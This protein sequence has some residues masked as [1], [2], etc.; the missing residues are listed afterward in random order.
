MRTS[1][2]ILSIV[3]SATV[4]SIASAGDFQ[5]L[6]SKASSMG[7]AGIAT[8][9]S[10]LA[11]YNNPALLGTNTEKL[12]IHI[13]AGV[14]AKDTGA[15]E[16]IGDLNDLDFSG[17][18]DAA[19][20]NADNLTANQIAAL[21]SAKNI[22]VGMDGK[23]I[24]MSPNADFGV[25]YGAFGTGLFVTSDIGAHANI[26]Q[27]HTDMI[28]ET[29]VAGTYVDVLTGN[30]KTLAEYQASSIDYAIKNGDT[31][32]EVI[33]LA[34]AEVPLAYGHSM[35]TEY[36]QV[37]IGGAL[38]LMSGKTFYKSVA[39]DDEN[40]FDNIDQ[41]TKT[42]TTFG[43][44]L[45]VAYK[46]TFDN[47]LT[48]ALVG[49]NLNSPKFD[50]V[51]GEE[52]KLDPMVRAGAAYK[53]GNWVELAFDA[54]LT[55]NKSINGNKSRY[56]GGGANFDLS[57]VELSAGLM[58]NVSSDDQAGLIY[59]AGISTGPSWLHF[60]LSAQMA[61]KSGEIDG[62]SYPKQASVNLAISSA[63]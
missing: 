49:K 3:A 23:G 6:G 7:G 25:S 14:T 33:G 13:G 43:V 20:G 61:S 62:T 9:P 1:K 46:P 59:T 8:S 51:N 38:K 15:G 26:L 48:L 56:I 11:S 53:F 45:G 2:I 36:G 31:N 19:D 47:S 60:E 12:S 37:S 5:V 10:A 41:N 35:T 44:D 39:L 18:K 21:G 40:A 32:L 27:S 24:A 63:W 4:A 30:A 55:E 17:L 22:I 52:F 57:V 42:S 50:V 29:S 28:F 16:S 54:D 58:K 34:V